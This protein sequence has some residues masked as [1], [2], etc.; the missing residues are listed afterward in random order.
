MN[1]VLFLLVNEYN[2]KNTLKAQ[3][4]AGDLPL[5]SSYCREQV[6]RT[7]T[8]KTFLQYIYFYL[9]SE[10]HHV[11]PDIKGVHLKLKDTKFLNWVY[12]FTAQ[13]HNTVLVN[14]ALPSF[15]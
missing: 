15:Q 1:G 13:I 7:Q 11:H 14:P 6:G 9:N 10:S 3:K 5:L 8:Y 12:L 4:K 2:F